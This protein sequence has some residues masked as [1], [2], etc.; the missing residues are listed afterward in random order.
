MPKKKSGRASNGM[1]SIRQRPD[2]RWEARYSLPDG[3]QKSV[4]AKTEKDVTQKLR[5][6]LHELDTTGWKE[7]SKLFVSDWMEVWLRDYQ[8][9]TI[10]R[11]IKTY[12]D[13]VRLHI[14]PVI[15][16]V[17]MMKLSQ[18]HV[19]RVVSTM[20]EKNLSATYVHQA[21]GVMSV[22]FNA[23][24]EAGVIKV[25]PAK[26]IKTPRIIK[27]KFTIVDREKIPEFIDAAKEDV[28][29]NAMIFLL[30]TGLRAAEERGLKWSDVD[31]EAATMEIERQLP[32]KGT[33]AFTAPKDGSARTIEL[34]PEAVELLRQQ[35]KAQAELR[36]AAGEKWISNPIVDDLVFRSARGW[37]VSES[38]L[39]K[40]VRAVGVKIGLPDLHPHDLRHSYA[41]AALRSGIDVK[42]VQNNLGHKNAAMTLDTYAGY[43]S[44]AG[45][46]GAQR[47]SDY[48]QNAL[49]NR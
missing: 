44:D 33:P 23:A 22:A 38:V 36:L 45:K 40:A 46:V 34:P 14:N 1:G 3:R 20:L 31:L 48:W 10:S 17:K 28:N 29:G 9:H 27:K 25:N 30:M 41:V 4:Y 2:G 37:F 16:R 35:K 13:I 11:T 43:T 47:F 15:G 8:A 39:H 21:H 49:K 42:T 32:C 26:G 12:S 19:R 18:I 7:P 5:A 24:V 6:A